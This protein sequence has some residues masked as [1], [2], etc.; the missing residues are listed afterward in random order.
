MYTYIQILYCIL[1]F[2]LTAAVGGLYYTK[3]VADKSQ[4]A[5]QNKGNIYVFYHIYC[6]KETISIVK[7]QLAKL[8]FSELYSKVT[9][10]YCFL[11]GDSTEITETKA[12]ISAYGSKFKVAAEGPGDKSYERFTLEKIHTYIKPDDKFVYIHSKGVTDK[13]GVPEAIYWWRTY[14]EYNLFTRASECIELLNTYDIVGVAYSKYIIGSHFS[15]NFWWSTGKYYLSLNRTIGLE[16]NDPESYIFTGN[17]NYNDIDDGR[18]SNI[19]TGSDLN[20]YKNVI[21]PNLYLR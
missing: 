8:V 19:P 20:L 3:V 17:P 7:D 5:F 12:L 4:E 18:F 1:L 11:T 16:Y 13:K 21:Y 14:M 10:V 15:G 2:V 6:N 9:T